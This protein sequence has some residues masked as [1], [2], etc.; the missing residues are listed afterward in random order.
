M[1]REIRTMS[2]LSPNISSDFYN[3]GVK[4]VGP[5]GVRLKQ[6]KTLKE[7]ARTYLKKKPRHFLT[8]EAADAYLKTLPAEVQAICEVYEFC[9][10]GI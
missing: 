8:R 1:Y 7:T 2:T 3:V 4:F 10:A 5:R 9:Y 6:D